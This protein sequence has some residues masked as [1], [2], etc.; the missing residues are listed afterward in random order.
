[1]LYMWG[2]KT[3]KLNTAAKNSNIFVSYR[4]EQY[5]NEKELYDIAKEYGKVRKI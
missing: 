2:L 3:T 4:E 1:M 5:L